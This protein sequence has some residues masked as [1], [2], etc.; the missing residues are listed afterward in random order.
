MHPAEKKVGWNKK[1]AAPLAG[2][3]KEEV[4]LDRARISVSKVGEIGGD[5]RYKL[6]A[7]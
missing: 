4:H 5:H 2:Y 3:L 1:K 7:E 6:W